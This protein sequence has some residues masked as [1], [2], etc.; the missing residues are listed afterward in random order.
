M[1]HE[2]NTNIL[3]KAVAIV[4]RAYR[5]DLTL[6]IVGKLGPKSY[7][8]YIMKLVRGLG[9]WIMLRQLGTRDINGYLWFTILQT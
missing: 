7:S 2:R 6:F 1:D 3:I 9:L 4:K 5:D 8:Q